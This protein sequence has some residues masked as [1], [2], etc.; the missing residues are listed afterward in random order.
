MNYMYVIVLCVLRL[1]SYYTTC[2]QFKCVASVSWSSEYSDYFNVT[3]GVK[4][5]GVISPILF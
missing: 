5:R 2:I 1:Q 3:N 4:Q